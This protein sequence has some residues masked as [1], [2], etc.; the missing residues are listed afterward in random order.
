MY[1]KIRK[2]KKYLIKY[3]IKFVAIG[4]IQFGIYCVIIL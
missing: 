3:L 4:T 2:I 1:G